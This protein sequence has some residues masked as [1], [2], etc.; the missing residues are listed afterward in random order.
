MQNFILIFFILNNL[1][2]K[3]DTYLSE[4]IDILEEVSAVTE[5]VNG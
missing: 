3:V 2:I 1:V 4:K 5:Q